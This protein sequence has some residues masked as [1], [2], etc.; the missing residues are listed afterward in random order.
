MY[1]PDALIPLRLVPVTDGVDRAW[2][3]NR[4]EDAFVQHEAMEFAILTSKVSDNLV[5]AILV[6]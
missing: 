1:R 4:G 5:R 3:V 6:D 2:K